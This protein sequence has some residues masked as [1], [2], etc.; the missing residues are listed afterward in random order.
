MR[1]EP[2]SYNCDI[3]RSIKGLVYRPKDVNSSGGDNILVVGTNPG[4]VL[5]RIT[6]TIS[7]D[8]IW[9]GI[10]L[11]REV[12]LILDYRTEGRNLRQNG[13]LSSLLCKNISFYKNR[14]NFHPRFSQRQNEL[15]YKISLAI[16]IFRCLRITGKT[17]QLLELRASS[18][19]LPK[20][21]LVTQ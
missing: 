15:F 19:R 12:L 20:D 21:A 3:S 18:I 7:F 1:N 9:I 14:C 5:N 10:A 13:K 8:N 11:M 2:Q 17:L 6:T 16:N 4:G